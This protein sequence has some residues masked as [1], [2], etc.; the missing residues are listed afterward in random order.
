MKTQVSRNISRRRIV[1]S[2][3]VAAVAAGLM[4]FSMMNG[5][6][7]ASA[8]GGLNNGSQAGQGAGQQ[9]NQQHDVSTCFFFTPCP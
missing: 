8:D 3:G 4:W 2:L 6:G 9:H 5:V 7:I 1:L